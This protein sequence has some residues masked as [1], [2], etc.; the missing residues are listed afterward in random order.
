MKRKHTQQKSANRKTKGF[1]AL[2]MK[3]SLPGMYSLIAAENYLKIRWVV[4]KAKIEINPRIKR[5]MLKK[6]GVT[7]GSKVMNIQPK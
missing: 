7:K 5:N 2:M 6:I 4:E 1:L 3:Q